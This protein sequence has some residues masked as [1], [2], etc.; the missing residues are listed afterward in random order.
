MDIEVRKDRPAETR[1]VDAPEPEPA[2][3]QALLRIDT[4]GLSTNNASF[5]LLGDLMGY[6]LLFPAADGA[7]GRVPVFGFADVVASR[8]PEVV[9]GTRLFGYLPMSTH[10]LVEPAKVGPRGFFDATAHRRQVMATVWNHYQ[11]VTDGDRGAEAQR[12]LLG[13]LFVTGFLM[14]DYLDDNGGFGADTVVVSAAS[15]RTA[16][17][18]AWCLRRRGG[19]RVVGLTSPARV[20]ALSGLGV[21]DE[22]LPYDAV[23]DLPGDRAVY[24]DFA[25]RVALRE[26]V[27][28]RFGQGLTHSM[29]AGTTHVTDPSGVVLHPPAVGAPPQPFMAQLQVAKR[30]QEWGQDVFDARREAAWQAFTAWTAGWLRI[31]D[32][33]G[34]DAVEPAWRALVAGDV[35]P[36]VGHQLSVWG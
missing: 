4:F 18:L 15:S 1:R 29:V 11:D 12:S 25:G 14:D 27:H 9:E 22:V 19:R 28:A 6:W 30:A 21:Y 24:V 36:A 13:P 31:E 10:L 32:G 20:A 17:A 16:L 5:A 35:D 34:P 7:W 2:D 33:R 23:A 26:A 8:H 3:G